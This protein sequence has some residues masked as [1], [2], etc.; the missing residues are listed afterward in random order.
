MVGFGLHGFLTHT[1]TS[2]IDVSWLL[3]TAEPLRCVITS[4]LGDFLVR[5]LYT[6]YT[7][8]F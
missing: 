5:V 3:F 6:K 1:V 8:E 2:G 7:R 4:H